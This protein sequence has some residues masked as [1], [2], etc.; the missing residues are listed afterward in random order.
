MV[1]F[2]HSF[3]KKVARAFLP[4]IPPA[5]RNARTTLCATTNHLFAAQ[6]PEAFTYDPDGNL[7]KDGRFRFP[8]WNVEEKKTPK[9]WP[10]PDIPPYKDK[11]PQ[12]HLK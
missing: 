5:G 3:V 1:L 6:S 12:E 2:P 11:P 7:T 8:V 4:V 10:N 9:R